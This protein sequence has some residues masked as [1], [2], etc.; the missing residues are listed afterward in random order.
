MSCVEAE[1]HHVA[2]LHDVIL[3][4]KTEFA[5]IAGPRF[6]AKRSVIVIGDGFGADESFFKIGMDDARGLRPA[7]TF[8]DGPGARFLGS[9]GEE[10]NEAQKIVT[11]ADQAIEARFFQAEA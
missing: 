3:A 5:A 9:G 7:R 8:L 10:G 11:G 1:M 2:V 4:F 6:A